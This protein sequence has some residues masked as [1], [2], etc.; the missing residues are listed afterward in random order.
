MRLKFLKE[1]TTVT[2][3]VTSHENIIFLGYEARRKRQIST[4]GH[5]LYSELQ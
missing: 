1:I 5:I 4:T 3:T 2:V